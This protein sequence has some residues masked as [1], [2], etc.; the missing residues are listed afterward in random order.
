MLNPTKVEDCQFP[1]LGQETDGYFVNFFQR[2]SQGNT[3][4]PDPIP[5]Y[6]E[7]TYSLQFP[8]QFISADTA[9]TQGV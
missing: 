9:D 5:Y 2:I 1:E 4:H 7:D 3:C 6:V 8:A